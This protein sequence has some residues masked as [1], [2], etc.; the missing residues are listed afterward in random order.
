MPQTGAMSDAAHHDAA[1]QNARGD[2]AGE[3]ARR[4]LLDALLDQKLAPLLPELAAR[5]AKYRYGTVG[6]LAGVV[7]ALLL[8]LATENF[9][10]AAFAFVG[11]LVA[12]G[13][14][15]HYAKLFRTAVQEAVTPLVTEAIGGMSRTLGAGHEVLGRLRSLPIV[16]PFSLHTFD[17]M[18]TGRHHGTEFLL[19]EIRLYNRSTRTTGSGHT[20]S[21]TTKET[22]VFKGLAFFIETPAA[23]PARI[24]LRGPRIPLFCDWRL[25]ASSLERLGFRRVAVPDAAFSRHLSLWAE[26]GEAA[27]GVIGPEL[28][29]TLARLAASAGWR[30]LDAGF[31]GAR[32]I[33][34]LPKGGN[35]FSIGGLFR[36]LGRLRQDAHAL[37]DEVMVVHRLIDVL[38]G[39]GG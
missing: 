22:T 31:S 7:A 30:R 36:P 26:D 10:L 35:S 12:Y 17:D 38:M 11:I 5:Q 37:M 8:F 4:A 34:L 29:A 25:G 3:A 13:A 19:A 32:F 18:F 9:E 24:I 27:L 33:L 1:H 14:L 16:M 2:A 28:A 6:A 21:T 23:I 15:T 20:R 39:K